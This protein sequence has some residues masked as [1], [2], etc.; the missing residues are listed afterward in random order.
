MARFER[1]LP[2]GSQVGGTVIIDPDTVCAIVPSRAADEATCGHCVL[3]LADGSAVRVRGD[4]T[5]VKTELGGTWDE[6]EPVAGRQFAPERAESSDH[7]EA[8]T[9]YIPTGSTAWHRDPVGGRAVR[10]C[11]LGHARYDYH[12]A[13][14]L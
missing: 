3:V 4:S 7:G 1:P 14:A 13:G 12:V 10:S 5:D 9:A 6:V 11:R 2:T 8:L